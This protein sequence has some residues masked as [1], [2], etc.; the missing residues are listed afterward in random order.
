[1]KH[2]IRQFSLGAAL[3]AL[4]TSCLNNDDPYNAGFVF[5]RPLQPVT[6]IFANT[7]EDSIQ[8]MSYGPWYLVREASWCTTTATQGQGGTVYSYPLTFEQNATGDSRHARLTFYDSD[9]PDDAHATIF[10]WQH[11][12]RGDGSLGLAADVRAISGSDG[13]RFEFAYDA[14]HRPTQLRITLGETQ[15]RNLTISYNEADSTIA[16]SDNGQQLSS[17]YGR[18]WQPEK[19]VGLTDT[20]GYAS[21]YYQNGVAV[22][23]SYAFNLE[24]RHANGQNRYYAY[25]VGG[26]NLSPD[27][28]HCADSLRIADMQGQ[29]TLV[30]KMKMEYSK[31]DNRYQ[32]IDV[33]QLITGAEQCD[34]YQLLSLF[35]Y[36][37]STSIVSL[38]TMGD[39]SRYTAEAT[40]NGNQSVKQLQVN[41]Y[42]AQATE[43]TSNVTYTFEY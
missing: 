43:P 18:D 28:L 27:S 4:T 1:M 10:Y 40:L 37:R 36:T 14:L 12:T 8:F 3:L 19:L 11:A 33:N 22:S 31:M 15:L 30:T 23:A 38:L 5:G 24:H 20:V 26:Q 17:K 29:S 39:G 41:R 42:D 21:Q 7:V 2:I 32:S 35:R 13:S 9:H 16:V 34:P 6:A 25:L